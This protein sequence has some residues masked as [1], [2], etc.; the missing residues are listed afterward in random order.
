MRTASRLV[1]KCWEVAI[2]GRCSPR[3]TTRRRSWP[4]PWGL[5]CRRT[6]PPPRRASRRPATTRPPR[7]RR[8]PATRIRRSRSR[9]RTTG[10][11]RSLLRGPQS[12]RH[13][14]FGA[15]RQRGAA[16]RQ[17]AG[18]TRPQNP[19]ARP[20]LALLAQIGSASDE[21]IVPP[22]QSRGR[23]V[24]PLRS[25]TARRLRR[26]R[27]ALGRPG[28]GPGLCAPAPARPPGRDAPRTHASRD[29]RASFQHSDESRPTTSDR[30]GVLHPT[31]SATNAAAT[32]VR[33]GPTSLSLPCKYPWDK[34]FFS[35]FPFQLALCALLLPSAM[36]LTQPLQ[37]ENIFRNF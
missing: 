31:S 8:S 3:R 12:S 18:S 6:W 36:L 11:S 4:P 2:F 7:S 34:L 29:G 21:G 35:L 10:T 26:P 23:G 27:R 9:S 25:R 33:E 32:D 16:A 22:F 19:S 24:R 5:T 37:T 30:H 14:K 1:S 13:A 20:P 15:P 17:G 28:P